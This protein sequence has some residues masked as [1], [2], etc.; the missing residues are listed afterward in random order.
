MSWNNV[1]PCQS[2]A[3]YLQGAKRHPA[4]KQELGNAGNKLSGGALGSDTTSL[5]GD[6][7][8]VPVFRATR[9]AYEKYYEVISVRGCNEHCTVLCTGIV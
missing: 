2:P 8:N 1:L 6:K 7:L 3:Q 5:N 9:L 4:G